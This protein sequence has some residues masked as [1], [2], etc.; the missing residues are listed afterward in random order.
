LHVRTQHV[1]TVVR[2]L[3]KP[4]RVLNDFKAWSTRALRE[5]HLHAADARV[6][7]G[8]GSTVYLWSARQIE[9]AA[10]YV[11]NRQ[12]EPMERYP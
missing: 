4:E 11:F 8:H 5:A 10:D 3:V 1:H 6:W 9:Q 2:S 12:G 7:A